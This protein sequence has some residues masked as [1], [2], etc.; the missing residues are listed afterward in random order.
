MAIF[1]KVLA[2]MGIGSARVDT[3]LYK[4]QLIAG[5]KIEGVIEVYGG[6]VEQEIDSIY[7]NLYTSYI[8]EVND[9]KVKENYLLNSFKIADPFVIQSQEKKEIPFSFDL[10]ADTPVTMGR[11]RVWIATGLDIKNAVDPSDVDHM[12]VL[13]HP[14]LH[15]TINAMSDM[16]FRLR[17]VECEEAPRRL[18]GRLPFLQEFEF[19]PTRGAFHGKLDEL[20]LMFYFRAPGKFDVLME[21][22]RR[23]R[24]ISGFLA[25]ALELDETLVRFT[26]TDEDIPQLKS[27][28]ES[29]VARYS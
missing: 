16:G 26:V 7:L 3:K 28:L 5:E 18:R 1:N 11:T 21:V 24:G 4:D 23:S 27:L 22:D 29:V 10:P 15:A 12:E 9:S 17:Q 14:I 25:E 8:R 20:E 6:N 19:V 2:R 13:P